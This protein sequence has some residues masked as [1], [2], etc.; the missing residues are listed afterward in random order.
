MG[1]KPCTKILH[2]STNFS[3]ED[4]AAEDFVTVFYGEKNLLDR[5][6]FLKKKLNASEPSEHPP[7]RRKNVK[8]F[9]WDHRL[10]IQNLFMAFKRVSR[11]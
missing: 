5:E 8:T 7:A 9:R 1:T 4:F 11:W 6:M 3:C 10:Q 2:F